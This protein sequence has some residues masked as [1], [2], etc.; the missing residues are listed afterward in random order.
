MM[1]AFGRTAINIGGTHIDFFSAGPFVIEY[2]GRRYRFE[3]GDMFGPWPLKKNDD[4]K[5]RPFGEKNPFWDAWGL[6]VDQGRRLADDGIT[7]IYE[8][9]EDRS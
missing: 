8:H 5:D 7:C 6:W 2:C 1:E 9:A 4:T 3:D